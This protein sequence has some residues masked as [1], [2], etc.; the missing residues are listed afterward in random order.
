MEATEGWPLGI[1]LA[2]AEPTRAARGPSRELL[3]DYFEEEVLGA[4]DPE[5]RAQILAA[6]AAP[7]LDLAAAAG[8]A[9]DAVSFPHAPADSGRAAFHPLFR[10]FLRRRFEE[11]T[12]AEQRRA[13]AARLADVLEAAGRGPDAVEQRIASEDW[14]AAADAVAREGG[15]LVRRAPETVDAWLAAL[16][17]DR[18]QRPDLTL[19]AGQLAHGSGRLGEAVEHCRAAVAAADSNGSPSVLC[20]SPPRFA[21]GDALLGVGDL[22]PPRPWATS[23]TIPPPTATCRRAPW[24]RSPRS[25]S[26]CR[27]ASIWS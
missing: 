21:L 7:D 27:A 15:A 25:H 1:V 12:P 5:R 10:E 6:A 22:P 20:A 19:L 3:D 16:P 11:E 23:S 13:I 26:P 17:A 14:D 4:L 2:A 9:P 24:A 8:L 18:S